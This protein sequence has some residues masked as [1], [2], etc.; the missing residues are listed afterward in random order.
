VTEPKQLSKQAAPAS[1]SSAKEPAVIRV[2]GCGMWNDPW[3]SSKDPDE[4]V[5]ENI[6]IV[7]NIF[8]SN[9][10]DARATKTNFSCS[11]QCTLLP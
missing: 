7:D 11:D 4:W 1:E 9:G 6:R 8:D 5:H 10:L 3:T 2:L